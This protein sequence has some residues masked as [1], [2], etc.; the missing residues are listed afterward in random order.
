MWKM[1]K[2]FQKLECRAILTASDIGMKLKYYLMSTKPLMHVIL[3]QYTYFFQIVLLTNKLVFNYE[4]LLDGTKLNFHRDL[5]ITEL[6]CFL[7]WI[8]F[9]KLKLY[10]C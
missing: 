2:I 3:T 5:F 7:Q 9:H 10:F 4:D 1:Q 8:P 6:G